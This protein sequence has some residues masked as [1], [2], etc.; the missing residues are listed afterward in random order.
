MPISS[1]AFLVIWTCT[2]LYK[3]RRARTGIGPKNAPPPSFGRLRNRPQETRKGPIQRTF[4]KKC[5]WPSKNSPNKFFWRKIYETRPCRSKKYSD[6]AS[7][8]V[9]G[10]FDRRQR[11]QPRQPL[12][13]GNFSGEKF[14][15]RGFAALKSYKATKF[16][17][18]ELISIGCK[19]SGEGLLPRLNVAKRRLL[20]RFQPQ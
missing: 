17:T 2:P 15:K 11:R 6:T 9:S 5:L 1:K 14:M 18:V 12:N 16:S 10:D 13:A 8:P 20:R 7:S 19:A 3:R 4:S